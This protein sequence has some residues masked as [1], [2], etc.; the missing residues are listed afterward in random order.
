MCNINSPHTQSGYVV[1]TIKPPI[2]GDIGESHPSHMQGA[3]CRAPHGR[4]NLDNDD[5]WLHGV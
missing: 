4:E 2:A 5:F 1:G 3:T